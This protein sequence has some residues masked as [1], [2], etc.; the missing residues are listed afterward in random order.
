MIVTFSR[1]KGLCIAVWKVLWLTLGGGES[2]TRKSSNDDET[3][4]ARR[5]GNS[6]PDLVGKKMVRCCCSSSY[7]VYTIWLYTVMNC[8]GDHTLKICIGGPCH[9]LFCCG[10][11]WELFGWK[12]HELQYWPGESAHRGLEDCAATATPRTRLSLRVPW[13]SSLGE[14]GPSCLLAS[15]WRRRAPSWRG[16]HPCELA[17]RVSSWASCSGR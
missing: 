16:S 6:Q 2:K 12:V 11:V 7:C 14:H 3:L 10:A 17:V 1:N 15:P 9:W 4:T 13:T 5:K 8:F